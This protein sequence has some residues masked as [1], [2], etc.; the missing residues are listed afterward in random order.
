MANQRIARAPPAPVCQNRDSAGHDGPDCRPVIQTLD[1][2]ALGTGSIVHLLAS[3]A[4]S[5]TT[6]THSP[7]L[8]GVI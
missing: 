3:Q 8:L 7:T 4:A 2:H 6:D 1:L 5:I